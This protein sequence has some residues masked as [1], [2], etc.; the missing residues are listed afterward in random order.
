MLSIYFNEEKELM[1]YYCEIGNIKWTNLDTS[2][3]DIDTLK[4]LG[5][6]NW[7]KEL[8]ENMWIKPWRRNVRWKS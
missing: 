5:E 6:I 4:N 2:T 8:N 1:K 7:H 3:I